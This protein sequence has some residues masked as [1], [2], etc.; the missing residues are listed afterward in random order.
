MSGLAKT[1]RLPVPGGELSY[2]ETGAGTPIVFLHAAIAD[3]RMWEREFRAYAGG[4]R[5]VRFDMRG[6]GA[7]PAATAPY[8]DS[9]DLAAVVDQLGLERPTLVG[10]SNGGRTVLDYAVQNPGKARALVLAAPGVAGFDTDL[11]PEG[12]EDYA[13]DGVRSSAIVKAWKA[14]DHARALAELQAY[15]CSA[16]DG[17]SKALVAQMMADNAQEIFTDT[18]AAFSQPLSP[19][20]VGRLSEIRVPTVLLLGDHDE[21]TMTHIVRYIAGQVPNSRFVSVPGADHLINLSRPA[22]FDAALQS[23][24]G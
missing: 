11:A 24:L 14:G 1:G 9:E 16:Q 18:S 5:V 20:T 13:R 17:A 15:W 6:L 12:N 8:S 22:A 10:C 4:H 19:P 21:P 2:D 7:S 23:V 3:R